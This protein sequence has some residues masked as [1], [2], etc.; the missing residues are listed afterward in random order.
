MISFDWDADEVERSKQRIRDIWNYKPVDRIPV[1]IV[2]CSNPDGYTLHD[3][4]RD[5][6]KQLKVALASVRRT[7]ELVPVVYVPAVTADVGNI[8]VEHGFG[9]KT[10]FPEDAEQSPWFEGPLIHDIEEVRELRI[11]NPCEHEFFQDSLKRLRQWV[12]KLEGRV[13]IGG[14][15]IGSPINAAMNLMDSTLFYTSLSDRPDLIHIL[16]DK[17]TQAFITYYSLMI[18][19]AGGLNNMA[20]TENGIWCPEGRK[21]WQADDVCATLSP[22]MFK[23]FSRPYTSRVYGVYGAGLFHNCGPNPCVFEY[24]DHDPPVGGIQV[25]YE[26][27]KDDIENFAKAFAHKAVVYIAWWGH[28]KPGKVIKEYREVCE[29][30]APY[31]IG[32]LQY[33]LD[34]SQYSDGDVLDISRE[35][36]A[37]AEEYTRAM[38]WPQRR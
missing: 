8:I 28:D 4:V 3:Q 34:D 7:L 27:S 13:Y 30:L 9:Q 25:F 37:V 24:V 11:P 32:I 26:Y 19:A 18:D 15:D 1:N 16:L 10:A 31:T 36:T 35:L 5:G 22:E 17:V 29:K 23:E 14:Y 6:D 20:S 21:T 38:V 12:A 33:W 2:V